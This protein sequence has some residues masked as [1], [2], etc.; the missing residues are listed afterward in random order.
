MILRLHEL[1][2][3]GRRALVR[4]DFNVPLSEDGAIVDDTRIREALPTLQE[5]RSAG[6]IPILLSHLGRPKGKPMPHLSLAP[7]ARHLATLLDCTVHFAPDCIGEPA[8]R[9]IAD[10][11]PGDVVVL[12]NLRF[13]PG[14][15]SNDEAFAAQLVHGTE[16]YVNDAF[17]TIHRAHASVVAL[18]RRMRWKGMGLLMEREITALRRLRDTAERPYVAIL[19]GAKVSDKLDVL[20]ALLQRCDVLLLGGGMAF[21]FLAA[22]G[23][24]IGNSLVEP[25]LIPTAHQ[26][27]QQADALGKQILLPVDVYCAPEL[28]NGAPVQLAL[29]SEGGIPE[30]WRGADIGPQ[31]VALFARQLESARTIFWNGPLGVY[32]IPAFRAGTLELARAIAE[33]TRRGAFSLV[34]GG[35]SVA[36]LRQLG[37]ESAVSHLSTGGGASLEFLAGRTLPGLEAL[38]GQ[39]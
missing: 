8:Q 27:L 15:E 35:D 38:E 23:V 1:P 24:Q 10:A 34:G 3:A 14:E 29:L 31:T 20:Q 22:R 33:A 32:E 39:S 28:R 12:E 30:G 21:T 5:L 18:P 6:A 4:V 2:I 26:L 25:D 11:R 19:G 16:V 36:A 9:S 13:H 7:V 17:G 37:M